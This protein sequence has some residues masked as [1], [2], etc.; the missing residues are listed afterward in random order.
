MKLRWIPLAAL[1]A[2]TTA[3]Q[4]QTLPTGVSFTASTDHR[5]DGFG[6]YKIYILEGG[7]TRRTRD[8]GKPQ[9]DAANMIAHVEPDFFTGL[10]TGTYEI[11]ATAYGTGGESAHSNRVGFVVSATSPAAPAPPTNMQPIY[12]TGGGSGTAAIL[13]QAEHFDQGGQGTAYYDLT[14][15]ND[16]GAYRDTDVDLESTA[17]AGGGHNVGWTGAGEWLNYTVNVPAPG[18]YTLEVRV[19]SKDPGGVFHIE[20]DG[21]DRTGPLTVPDTRGWQIWTTVRRTGVQLQAGTQTW[22]L[23]MDSHSPETGFSGNFNWIRAVIP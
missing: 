5:S 12:D 15:G 19:A 4:A 2:A 9:P 8:I 18:I 21:V 1:L 6:G 7:V 13:V 11:A 16:G 22:R 10:P 3:L 14:P 23:V 20:I 17:D